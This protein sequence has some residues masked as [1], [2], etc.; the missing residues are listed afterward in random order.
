MAAVA[1][2]VS[3]L[4]DYFAFTTFPDSKLYDNNTLTKGAQKDN[5]G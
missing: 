2:P 3:Q 5:G 4:N 1:S